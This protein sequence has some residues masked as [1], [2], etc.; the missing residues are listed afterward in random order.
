MISESRNYG[1]KG[2]FW[3]FSLNKYVVTFA[4]KGKMREKWMKGQARIQKINGKR[5]DIVEEIMGNP[6]EMRKC[7]DSKDSS[8]VTGECKDVGCKLLISNG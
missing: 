5:N 2:D 1:I 7:G 4:R 6:V 8:E 3:F